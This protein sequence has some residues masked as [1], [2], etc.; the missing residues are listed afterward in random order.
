M[1]YTQIASLIGATL[2]VLIGGLGMFFGWFSP[3][4]GLGLILAG[5]SILGVHT[6]GPVSGNTRR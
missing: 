1:S 5:L 4:E 6:S 2:A 3:P